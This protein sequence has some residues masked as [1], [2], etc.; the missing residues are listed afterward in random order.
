MAD[1]PFPLSGSTLIEGPT[2]VGK[3]TLTARALEAWI[4]EHGADG[5]VVLEFAPSIERDG[6][7]VG[8]RMDRFVDVPDGVWSGVLDAH[9]PRLT[10]ETDAETAR[11]ARENAEGATAILAQ[12]PEPRAVFVNDA[13]IPLQT[14]DDAVTRLTDYCDRADCVV[15]NAFAGSELGTDDPVSR[16]EQAA[17]DTLRAWA[18]R[19]H[20][21][22]G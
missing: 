22:T 17:L 19:T 16:R 20:T 10:G 14:D 3:T 18:D 8:G 15:L 12:A 7:T 13:T 5:V 6:E 9:A 11:L 1:L 4:G 21:L 2:Q